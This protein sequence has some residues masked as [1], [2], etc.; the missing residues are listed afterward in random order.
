LQLDSICQL[1]YKLNSFY[2]TSPAQREYMLQKMKKVGKLQ[3]VE[4][5]VV[6]APETVPETDKTDEASKRSRI[7]TEQKIAMVFIAL[8]AVLAVAILLT[9]P[10]NEIKHTSN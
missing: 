4:V 5:E 7:S 3:N 6:E 1:L 2:T 10:R 9:P 8:T